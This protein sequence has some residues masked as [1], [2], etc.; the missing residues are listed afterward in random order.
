MNFIEKKAHKT[1]S[2]YLSDRNIGNPKKL[3]ETINNDL[4]DVDSEEDKTSYITVILEANDIQY[5]NHLKEC[6]NPKTCSTNEAHEE[7]NYFL[8]QEL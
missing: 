6:L 3:L 1:V 4:Y 7:V 2:Y 8:H 5:A